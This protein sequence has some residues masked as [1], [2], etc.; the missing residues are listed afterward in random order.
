MSVRTS[1]WPPGV[2]CWVELTTP[3][4]DAAKA[5][6]A[7]VCGWEFQD[8]GPDFGSYAIGQLGGKAVAGLTPQ[9]EHAPVGWLLYIASDDVDATARAIGD[10]GG[11]LTF[12]P[13]DVRELGRMC[14]ATD[15][16]GAAFAVWQH[17][18][19]IGAEVTNEP[20]GLAWEDLRSPDPDASRAFFSGVFG[21]HTDPIPGVPGDYTTF[22]LPGQEAPLGGI[23][24][25]FGDDR[26][27]AWTLYFGVAD[28]DAAVA[29]VEAGGGTVTE[30]AHDTPYGRMAGVA[31]PSG[32]GFY[33]MRL[34]DEWSQGSQ[35]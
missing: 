32:A 11:T 7:G 34:P 14:V 18:T 10:N 16:H 28:T 30:P 24:G 13:G 31:D 35:G 1:P 4:V 12:P 33:V 20:G 8:T 17:G 27:P 23:G 21:Y 5:F 6:Y 29:A 22:A 3:D 26:T 2:P 19:M 9:Q 25:F 15:P